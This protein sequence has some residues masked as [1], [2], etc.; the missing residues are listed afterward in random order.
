L[1]KKLLS[2]FVGSVINDQIKEIED[3]IRWI[4]KVCNTKKCLIVFDDLDKKEQL[5]KLA[6]EF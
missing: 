2:S 5:E 6:R 4:K 3:G 1:Q